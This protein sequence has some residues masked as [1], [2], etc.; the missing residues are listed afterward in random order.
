MLTK[1][2]LRYRIDDGRIGPAFLAPDSPRYGLAVVGL[3]RIICSHLGKTRGE[4]D[5]AL[6]KFSAGRTDYRAI[7]G[8][9][10]ILLNRAEF[11]SDADH[12]KDLRDS[13]FLEA[14]RYWPI[15]R[16][17]TLPQDVTRQD[18]LEK[19][20]AEV[21]RPPSELEEGLYDDLPERQRLLRIDTTGNPEE[22]IARYNLELA[23]GL[24]YD[25][26]RVV[27][28]IEDS[29]QDVVRYIKLCRLM[30][31]LS[32]AEHGYRIELDGPLSLLRGTRRYGLKM[33]VF[34]PALALCQKWRMEAVIVKAGERLIFTL[35]DRSGLI[36]HFRRFPLFDSKLESD[37]AANFEKA[38][39]RGLNEWTL[40][41]ADAILPAG[42][43]NVMIPDFTLRHRSGKE[44]YLEI[45]GFWT[46]EYL[47]R[48]ILKARAAELPN[49]LLAVSK[50]LAL[51]EAFGEDLNVLWF[52]GKLSTAEV[53]E[54]AEQLGE[55]I[56]ID[57]IAI[58]NFR[59]HD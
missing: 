29:Y 56:S 40:S 31:D 7:R 18:I 10:K 44:V 55:K 53:I 8:L 11:V 51:S 9:A 12:A 17:R 1:D 23:R 37:F 39:R 27:I 22:T 25:A 52:A 45:V 43:N 57:N 20:A 16:N 15:T 21:G 50:R 41:R 6:E 2:L 3:W 49:L 28:E 38:F 35:D 5:S 32:R 13:V 30:H 58:P 14:A 59:S 47:R 48:K 4:L 19:V 34:L 33:A 46:P 42:G 36:S 54:R 24:L 26:E